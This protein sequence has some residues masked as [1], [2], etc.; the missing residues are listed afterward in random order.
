MMQYLQTLLS[1]KRDRRGVTML[2]YGLIAALVAVVAIGALTT[3][4][5]N[6]SGVFSAISNKVT[7]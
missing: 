6:L 1:L 2:E 7:S 3:L 5:T 4:G